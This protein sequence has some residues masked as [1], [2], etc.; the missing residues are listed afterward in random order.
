MNLQEFLSLLRGVKGNG[1]QFSALCPAHDDHK[2][3]L[4]ISVGRN[5][6]I[7]VN[8]HAGCETTAVL[9][10]VG[11]KM[12][13]LY[14]DKVKTSSKAK[15]IETYDYRSDNGAL[16]AQKLR[17]ADKSFSW[18]QPDGRKQW[19]YKKPQVPLLYNLSAL[20]ADTIYIVEG[21]KDVQTLKRFGKAAVS[22][23]DG[24]G[25]EGKWPASFNDCFRRKAV[26][27]IQDNDVVGK[28]FAIDVANNLYGIARSLKLLDLTK[29][30]PDLPEH[31]DISDLV[32]NWGERTI[33]E[34]DELVKN[35]QEYKWQ[36]VPNVNK[37]KIKR[38]SE[39]EPKRAEYLFFPYIPK[40]KL[41]IFAGV[42]GA[43]KTWNILYHA[44]LVSNGGKYITDNILTKRK[45]GVVIYQTKENDY[46]NDIRPRL[47]K[48]QANLNNIIVID[49]HDEN[50]HAIPLTLTDERIEEAV[51]EHGASLVIFDPIQSYLG[52]GID[53]HRANEVR[54]ILDK[55]NDMAKRYDCSIVLI[56]H[57]SKQTT[58]T[59]LDRILGSS[60]LRNAARS[61]CII[62]HDPNDSEHRVMVHAKNSLGLKGRSIAYHI[63]DS[64]GVVL[65]G[66]CD[67]DEDT[68]VQPFKQ[69][70][71]NKPSI[72][73][74]KAVDLLNEMLGEQ[75]YASLEDIC[76]RAEECDI[77][78]STLYTAKK[79][80]FIKSMSTG[81]SSDKVTWWMR[82]GVDP[83][84]IR[85][86]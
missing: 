6:S 63:D 1:N 79:E 49:D 69:I 3:S 10:A 26:V 62:G 82:P 9:E 76:A 52:S 37:V 83:D 29:I 54:P 32:D 67:L 2:Q 84:I 14:P 85:Q 31:G 55:L 56:S 19:I 16:L 72:Q 13:D 75:G 23:A 45:P 80:L 60:D 27:I 35:T 17:K 38:M 43:T 64:Q 42:S 58:A 48:L 78:N 15:V 51:K 81:F 5:G 73:K 33:V 40:G 36:Y 25:G 12:K 30:Y 18:R 44:A 7:V 65:D 68:I 57:M 11:L 34:I 71:R 74:N 8:C 47:D 53:M 21:E 46:E 70:G 41:T 22:A 24:A 20:Q 28:A 59:A 50:G 61:I 77:K 66:F 4:S 86:K 39:I